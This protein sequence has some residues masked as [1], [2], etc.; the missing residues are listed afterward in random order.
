[1]SIFQ[2]KRS[3][4]DY[5]ILKFK[6]MFYKLHGKHLD[7]K[8]LDEL[9]TAP[10]STLPIEIVKHITERFPELEKLFDPDYNIENLEFCNCA[11]KIYSFKNRKHCYYCNA[12][13]KE[14]LP[15]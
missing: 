15:K 14:H 10:E 7:I 4:A 8:I 13:I 5:S 1:M 9:E 2:T 6:N 3:A 11:Y 12:P